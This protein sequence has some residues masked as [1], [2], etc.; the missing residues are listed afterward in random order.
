M[1]VGAVAEDKGVRLASQGVKQSLSFPFSSSSNRNIPLLG[2]IRFTRDKG[3]QSACFNKLPNVESH[4][5]SLP[6]YTN[7]FHD[8]VAST[9]LRTEFDNHLLLFDNR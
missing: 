6:G 3:A 7:M 1:L 5:P 9:R 8:F 2:A 4:R